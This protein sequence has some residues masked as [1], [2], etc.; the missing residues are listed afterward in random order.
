MLVP[1][2]FGISE[3]ISKTPEAGNQPWRSDE[4][5]SSSEASSAV[6][7]L[8]W[9]TINPAVGSA[10][11]PRGF[12][13]G[14]LSLRPSAYSKNAFS[15]SLSS[16]APGSP[17]KLVASLLPGLPPV[18]VL[19]RQLRA[20]AWSGLEAGAIRIDGR[21]RVVELPHH[22]VVALHG[23]EEGGRGRLDG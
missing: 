11:N 12:P 2:P 20:S 19:L 3:S 13:S 21:E 14:R 15:P 1:S 7:F 17:S 23:R 10:V 6:R 16:S 4:I 22:G 9:L 5:S 18:E 8:G